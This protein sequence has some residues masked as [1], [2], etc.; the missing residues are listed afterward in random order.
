MLAINGSIELF[1]FMCSRSY[2]RIEVSSVS[3]GSWFNNLTDLISSTGYPSGLLINTP[4]PATAVMGNVVP[5]GCKKVFPCAIAAVCFLK[6]C[7]GAIT[8]IHPFCFGVI[9]FL[10][11]V[12]PLASNTRSKGCLVVAKT[13]I[14]RYFAPDQS[15]GSPILSR[16]QK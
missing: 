8:L 3:A 10:I 9:H 6:V 5:D 4:K 7:N 1:I 15:L 11:K 2:K 12:S 16:C 14:T 13:S